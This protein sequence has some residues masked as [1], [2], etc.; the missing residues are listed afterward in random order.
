[1]PT[2]G[3]LKVSQRLTAQSLS[4]TTQLRGIFTQSTEHLIYF[5]VELGF[6]QSVEMSS[7]R[8]ERILDLNGLRG[9]IAILHT[10]VCVS[11]F[12]V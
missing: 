3:A 2:A 10:G 11:C 6:F 8:L 1:M 7:L 12:W 4:F 5:I 9:V